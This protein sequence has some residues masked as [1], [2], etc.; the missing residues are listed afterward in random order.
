MA[1]SLAS[2]W[3]SYFAP[4]DSTFPHGIDLGRVPAGSF[5]RT[6]T[7][8]RLEKHPWHGIRTYDEGCRGLPSVSPPWLEPVGIR[9][10][11]LICLVSGLGWDGRR[12]TEA[13]VG[14][15]WCDAPTAGS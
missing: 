2:G 3:T 7:T 1:K 10:R 6:S 5:S 14:C 4:Q 9:F 15:R 12:P 13:L 11:R 8:I